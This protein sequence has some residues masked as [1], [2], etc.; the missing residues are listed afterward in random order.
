MARSIKCIMFTENNPHHILAPTLS[1]LTVLPVLSLD[2]FAS[3]F[4]SSAHICFYIWEKGGLYIYGRIRGNVMFVFLRLHLLNV[5]S[6]F[7]EQ[8]N[9]TFPIE[10]KPP[11]CTSTHLGFF[12]CS[13][14]GK[15]P[16]SPLLLL[17]RALFLVISLVKGFSFFYSFL[18]RT[19]SLF[20]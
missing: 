20:H 8:Q 4:L 6:A 15:Y 9:F 7:L 17:T 12:I 10:E 5:A 1:P 2:S 14:V 19:I 18:Q 11:V 16:F 13:C 3:A